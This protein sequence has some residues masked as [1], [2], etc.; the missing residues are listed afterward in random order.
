MLRDGLGG[1]GAEE[2]VLRLRKTALESSQSSS[3]LRRVHDLRVCEDLSGFPWFLLISLRSEGVPV[4]IMAMLDLHR[5]VVDW[6]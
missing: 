6:R 4:V 5:P 3:S 1:Y 2:V